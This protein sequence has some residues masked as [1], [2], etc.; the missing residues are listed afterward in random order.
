[1]KPPSK[2]PDTIHIGYQDIKILTVD[3][4]DE[5]V[6]AYVPDRSEI[7]IKEGTEGRELL[8]T[9]LHE[10]LHAVVQ[11]YG[12]RDDFKDHEHEEKIINA[13]GNGL[14]EVLTRNPVLASWVADNAKS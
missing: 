1:M 10:C 11:C 6:G 2:L 4:L 8:N 3:F 14:T 13:L 7:R 12:M 9:L 5:A